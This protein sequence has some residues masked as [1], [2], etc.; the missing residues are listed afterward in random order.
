MMSF[1]LFATAAVAALCLAAAP[2]LAQAQDKPAKPA[3][4]TKPKQPAKP[5]QAKPAA[6][7]PTAPAAA[8]DAPPVLEG[9]SAPPL[10]G[11]QP[12]WVK[13]CQT[14]PQVK[15]EV[16]LTNR[17]LRSETGQ[18]IMTTVVINV[19]A[20]KKQTLRLVRA[21]RVN[22]RQPSA[23]ILQ[24]GLDGDGDGAQHPESLVGID[25]RRIEVDEQF[26]PRDVANSECDGYL[27]RQYDRRGGIYA[28]PD[29]LRRIATHRDGLLCSRHQRTAAFVESLQPLGHRRIGCLHVPHARPLRLVR[30]TVLNPLAPGQFT[31]PS[32]LVL[33]Q[34]PGRGEDCIRK[35]SRHVAALPSL[36][37]QCVWQFA[38]NNGALGQ[39]RRCRR[40]DEEVE[41]RQPGGRR[42]RLIASGHEI[43]LARESS[44]DR[45]GG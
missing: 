4:T 36:A 29:A 19:P 17:A 14:D 28:K 22:V 31:N 25:Q 33:H 5:A 42:L 43:L 9:A 1:R 44:S 34:H 6:A 10:S 40:R 23:E 13:V 30:V 37:N 7:P 16:C 20:D 11:A 35:P 39:R 27:I 38:C 12:D 41:Q 2:T 15:K 8:D 18:T 45:N 21:Q 26:I 32:P 3:A 24:D